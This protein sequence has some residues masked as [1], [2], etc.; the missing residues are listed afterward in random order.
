MA[1]I[2]DII[3]LSAAKNNE[4][5]YV[6]QSGVCWFPYSVTYTIEDKQFDFKVWA[7][8]ADHA[9]EVLAAI[10]QTGIV[11]GRL[12]GTDTEDWCI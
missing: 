1:E 11:F 6:D 8:N 12:V 9:E 7:R 4:P 3:P 10:K 2:I 5:H